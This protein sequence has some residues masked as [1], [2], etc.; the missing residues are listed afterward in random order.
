VAVAHLP[1]KRGKSMISKDAE[2][3]TAK[4]FQT[5]LVEKVRGDSR[6][7]NLTRVDAVAAQV[8]DLKPDEIQAGLAE[9]DKNDNYRDIKSVVAATGTVYLFSDAYIAE[10][11][12]LSLAWIEEFQTRLVKETR[13]DSKYMAELTRVDAVAGQMPDLKPEEIEAGLAGI[14]KNDNYRDIKSVVAATGTIY[15]FSETYMTKTYA[16]ILARIAANDPCFAIAETVRE[17]SKIYPRATNV[18]LFKYKPFKM[19]RDKLDTYIARTLEEYKDIKLI[20]TSTGVVYLHSTQYMDEAQAERF[21][22]W[23]ERKK[24]N[25]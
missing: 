12:A 24:S 4:Q 25:D 7:A 18:E 3:I 5:H 22:E 9:I 2:K 21:V 16:Q 17:E 1:G 8:L 23:Y 15:L 13:Q 10:D 11:R 14:A 20:K 19:A 6:L